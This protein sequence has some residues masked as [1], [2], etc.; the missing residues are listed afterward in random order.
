MGFL[1]K[2]GFTDQVRKS[3]T[4]AVAATVELFTAVTI[5]LLPTPAKFHYTFNLR[6]VSKVFQGILM[7]KP[8]SIQSPD[9]FAR[10]WLH[11][12]FRVFHDRLINEDD[13]TFFKE[14]IFDFLK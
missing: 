6:D 12:S 10:L 1:Q 3:G 8:I 4:I 5:G 14:T 9:N 7:S 2:G 11:E 13:R